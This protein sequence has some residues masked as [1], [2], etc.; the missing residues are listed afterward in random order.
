MTQHYWKRP[1]LAG[2]FVESRRPLKL[3]WGNCCRVNLD[4]HFARCRAGRRNLTFDE[5]LCSS[6]FVQVHCFHITLFMAT[7][8]LVALFQ[9]KIS[10]ADANK[11]ISPLPPKPIRAP[12]VECGGKRSA[13]PLWSQWLGA[14]SLKAPSPLRSAGA[15]HRV[16]VTSHNPFDMATCAAT[17]MQ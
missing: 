9:S 7:F 3:R 8:A 5:R 15:L 10:L 11:C 16:A 13:T 6:F 2:R 1:R 14:E 17:T 4:Q 12:T